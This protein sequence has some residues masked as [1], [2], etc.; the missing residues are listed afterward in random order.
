MGLLD[1]SGGGFLDEG[2]SSMGGWWHLAPMLALGGLGLDYS[3]SV[4]KVDL[5]LG[6]LDLGL[7]FLD[8]LVGLEDLVLVV[9]LAGNC[10][11][12]ARELVTPASVLQQ[13]S[14]VCWGT[15]LWRQA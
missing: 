5:R 4:A 7:D 1:G 13:R 15:C 8:F 9:A 10:G 3:E 14:A 6:G 2:A 11:V 12:G